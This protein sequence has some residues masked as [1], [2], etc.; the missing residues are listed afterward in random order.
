M[1]QTRDRNGRIK[2]GFWQ[3]FKSWRL[4]RKIAKGKLPRGRVTSAQVME[5]IGTLRR[6][7]AIQGRG[8]LSAVLTKQNGERADLGVISVQKITTAFRDYIVDALQNSTT[9]PLS[10]FRYHGCGTGSTAEANTQTGL[11]TEVG[12]RVEGTQAEGST[13]NIYQSVATIS[14]SGSYAITEHG[15]FSASS[16]GTLMDR[17]LFSAI[18]VAS[19]DSIQFTYEATFNAEA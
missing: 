19:G 3:R 13:A 1:G 18:N 16:N 15:I 2:D 9:H 10:A 11:I 6:E 8:V 12:A 14:F 4:G 17:S 5:A 7:N